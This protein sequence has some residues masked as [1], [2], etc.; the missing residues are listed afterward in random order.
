MLVWQLVRIENF[1]FK[2][3]VLYLKI[4]LISHPTNGNGAEK[5]YKSY[6]Q[7]SKIKK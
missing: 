5:L 3:A 1:E 7:N 2:P 6:Q 4:D